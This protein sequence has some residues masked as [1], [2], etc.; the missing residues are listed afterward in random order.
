MEHIKWLYEVIDN[1]HA[2]KINQDII[3]AIEYIIGGAKAKLPMEKEQIE[4]A[5]NGGD[6]AYFYSKET[7]RDFSDGEEYYIETYGGDK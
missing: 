3:Q 2:Q 5:W 7:G 4:D 6:Y 1:A